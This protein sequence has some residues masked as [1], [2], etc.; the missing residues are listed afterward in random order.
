MAEVCLPRPLSL[1][2][3]KCQV[4]LAS[5]LLHCCPATFTLLEDVLQMVFIRICLQNSYEDVI[6]PTGT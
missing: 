3:S 2:K 6:V 1:Q 4:V 5:E